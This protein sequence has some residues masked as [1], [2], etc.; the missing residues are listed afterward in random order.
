M[1]LVSVI[2]PVYKVE[3]YLA[4]CLESVINQTYKD[5]EILLIYQESDDDCLNI[6]KFYQN[7]DRRIKVLF[8]EEKC[9]GLARDKGIDSANGEW[10]VFV[11]S[12]DYVHPQ[13]VEILL[14]TVESTG[15][16][17]AQCRYKKV[18]NTEE[19]TKRLS[20]EK[21]KVRLY[22]WKEYFFEVFSKS[23]NGHTPFGVWC[24]IY[25]KSLFKEIRFGNIRFAEDSWFTPR[26]IYAAKEKNIAIIDD[27][28]YFYYQREDSLLHQKP[29]MM[30]VDRFF[31]K[32]NAMNFWLKNNDTEMYTLFF[33][34][35]L[36]CLILD[37]T[38]LMAAYPTQKDELDMIRQEIYKVI[39]NEDVYYSEYTTL[40]PRAKNYWE[41]IAEQKRIILYG[42]GERGKEYKEWLM[43]FGIRI[44][45][46]WDLKFESQEI[47]DGILYTKPHELDDKQIPIAIMIENRFI[48]G[49]VMSNLREMGY[50]VFIN[51]RIVEQAIKYKK[52]EMYLPEI[53]ENYRRLL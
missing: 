6:C 50:E 48:M 40:H 13:Y 28:L 36:N 24:N 22:S 20:F 45:E 42:Y 52:Y 1:P 43:K 26:I 2:I 53:I 16:L 19:I 7:K 44:E 8:L 5:L 17:T 39:N 37:Y 35:Y 47:V 38:D 11:D 10:I 41:M 33:S 14:K 46:I 18:F 23:D 21:E 29:K 27:T 30:R 51:Y 32:N 49:Q 15:C 12:D 3:K 34:D 9:L 31:A 4:R 25:H